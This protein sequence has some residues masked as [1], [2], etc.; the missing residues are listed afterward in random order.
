[1]LVVQASLYTAIVCIAAILAHRSRR[2][3]ISLL[4]PGVIFGAYVFLYSVVPLLAFS[5]VDDIASYPQADIRLNDD[6]ASP[7]AVTAISWLH[8]WLFACFT[9]IYLAFR[10]KSEPF[11][12]REFHAD[13]F[14]LAATRL[15]CTVQVFPHLGLSPSSAAGASSDGFFH[16]R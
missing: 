16:E 10:M 12:A 8:L 15:S 3:G 4:E 7:E 1:M 11:R 13:D 5:F 6:I 9:L 14:D 2:A